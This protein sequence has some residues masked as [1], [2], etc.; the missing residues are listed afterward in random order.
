MA[1]LQDDPLLTILELDCLP[2]RLQQLLGVNPK[3]WYD[4]IKQGVLPESGTYKEYLVPLFQH[5][6]KSRSN[7]KGEGYEK[8]LEAQIIQKIKLDQANEERLHINNLKE[9]KEVLLKSELYELIQP[10]M[11]NIVNILR[12]AADEEPKLQPIIDKAF[13][14]IYKAGKIL[15]EQ[16]EADTNNYVDEMLSKEVNLEEIL[17]NSK[18]EV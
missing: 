5:Y 4:L 1:K 6:S 16:V 8:L 15:A 11:G 10:I 12:A 2:T 18:L 7:S 9:R 14:S 3:T 17:N 13:E